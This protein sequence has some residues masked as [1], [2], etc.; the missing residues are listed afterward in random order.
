MCF[1]HVE[2]TSLFLIDVR[3]ID[4]DALEFVQFEGSWIMVWLVMY[5]D[6]I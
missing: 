3:A 4:D 1:L 2:D 5:V 6:A